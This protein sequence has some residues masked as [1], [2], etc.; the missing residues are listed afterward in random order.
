V[1]LQETHVTE[2]KEPNWKKVWDGEMKFANGTSKSKGVAILLPKCLD[3]EIIDMKRDPGGRYIAIKIIIE[4]ITYGLI[5][6]YAPTSNMLEAQ[7]EWLESI[8]KLIEDYGDTK[9]IFGGDINDGMTILDKFIG[10]DKWK[11]S[12]Y[13]LGWKETLREYQLVDIWRILFPLAHKYTWKQGTVPHM[14]PVGVGTS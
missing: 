14:D 8:N 4:E 3:Y 13:V 1:F 5:N 2:N 7:L 9:I 6:G 12:A 11:E 10:R